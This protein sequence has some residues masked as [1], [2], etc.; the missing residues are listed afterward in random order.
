MLPR[1]AQLKVL[2]AGMIDQPA[3]GLTPPLPPRFAGNMT[4]RRVCIWTIAAMASWLLV[5][6]PS[7]FGGADLDRVWGKVIDP[8]GGA[9]AGAHIRVLDAVGTVVRETSSDQN[10]SFDFGELKPG[11]YTLTAEASAFAPISA[12]VSVLAGQH[13]EIKLRFRQIASMRQAITV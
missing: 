2:V 4:G 3:D 10:G 11:D 13:A 1:T 6:C 5:C 8:D 12:A 7:A 9:V